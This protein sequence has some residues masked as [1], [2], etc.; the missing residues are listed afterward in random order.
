MAPEKKWSI[1]QQDSDLVNS[2]SRSCGCD[3]IL[4]SLL[5]NRGIRDPQKALAFLNPSLSDISSPFLMKDMTKAVERIARALAEKERILIFGDYDVDGVTGT[6]LL[7]E[8]LSNAEADVTYYIPDR[9]REGYGLNKDYIVSNAVAANIRLIIT[10]DCGINSVEAVDAA[11]HHDMDVIVTDHHETPERLPDAVAILNPKQAECTFPCPMLA[12]VGVAFYLVLALRKHLRDKGFWA[13]RTEPNLK[14]VCDLVALGTVADIVPIKSENR[15]LVKTGLDVLTTGIRPG[16]NA[17]KEVSGPLKTELDTWDIAF[18]LAPRI[19]AAGRLS[20]ARAAVELLA[21]PDKST[22]LPAAHFLNKTNRERQQIEKA[23][24]DEV[25]RFLGANPGHLKLRS[26]VLAG[27][28]WNE[29]VIGIVASK[30][31]DL[32]FRPVVLISVRNGRAKGSARS[33]PG[34]NIHEGLKDCA[35]YLDTFGG[36]N[37]AAGLSLLP[38]NIPA[39]ASRFERVVRG[40]SQAQDFVRKIVIDR[41]VRFEEINVGLMNQIGRMPPFGQG[42]P[43]PLFAAENVRIVRHGI[44]GKKHVRMNLAQHG[45]FRQ[46]LPAIWYNGASRQ[47]LPDEFRKIAFHMRWN[48]WRNRKTLQLVIKE[49][50]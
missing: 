50:E 28:G 21:A 22:A 27:N 13:G 38:K 10:V 36:H 23:I 32:Y 45:C 1:Q 6:T 16:V 9:F 37:A 15:I 17:L 24:L 44:V 49:A 47:P 2:L 48:L 25:M 14:S 33:I 31:L 46:G 7:L 26:I 30:L 20:Q 11:N 18:K 4:A 8:F 41:M 43:E 3:S 29:G 34:F 5:I 39:F 40:K 12:G 35:R 42:N 19:N